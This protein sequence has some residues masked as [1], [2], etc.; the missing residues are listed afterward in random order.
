MTSFLS[1]VPLSAITIRLANFSWHYSYL[2]SVTPSKHVN[3]YGLSISPSSFCFLGW[4]VWSSV[5]SA[6]LDTDSC[7]SLFE[8]SQTHGHWGAVWVQ[9]LASFTGALLDSCSSS[10][11]IM[12]WWCLFDSLNL[13]LNRSILF[14]CDLWGICSKKELLLNSRFSWV[15]FHGTSKVRA[16]VCVKSSSN[17]W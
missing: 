1:V 15:W 10:C 4:S 3:L 6:H 7:L 17:P 9:A 8:T 11:L 12:A 13:K 5:I 14:Y 2:L 16:W